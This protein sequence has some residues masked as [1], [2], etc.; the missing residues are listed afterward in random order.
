MTG[1]GALCNEISGNVGVKFGVVAPKCCEG[2]DEDTGQIVKDDDCDP[3]DNCETLCEVGNWMCCAIFDLAIDSQTIR[4]TFY[5]AWLNGSLYLPQFKIKEKIKN[6]GDPT[7]EFLSQNFCGPGGRF[8]GNDNYK[9]QVCNGDKGDDADHGR[10]LARENSCLARSYAPIPKVTFFN[11]IGGSYHYQRDFFFNDTNNGVTGHTWQTGARDTEEFVYCA[12]TYPTKIVNIGRTDACNNVIETINRV[13]DASNNVLTLYKTTGCNSTDNT[14]YTGTYYGKG[15]D[16]EQ[17]TDTLGPNSYNNPELLVI[18]LLKRAGN[19][20]PKKIFKGGAIG[21]A[22]NC[23]EYELE[24]EYWSEL[25]EV[26]KIYVDILEEVEPTGQTKSYYNG[27]SYD[28]GPNQ[29]FHPTAIRKNNPTPINA[30]FTGPNLYQGYDSQISTP[31]DK[32]L[33]DRSSKH[34]FRNSPYF[35]FGINPGKTSI[36]KLRK[37]YLQRK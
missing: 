17:W 31:Y 8:N 11:Q 24:D 4:Y 26:S 15:Y 7:K 14:C 12:E 5:D 25:N 18:N 13:I 22:T 28:I 34:H 1:V 3:E 9:N 16:T 20:K 29:K 10:G 32:Q 36:D 23:N 35:Y 33:G 2:I 19:C 21:S 30:S 37:L 27:L 6:Q